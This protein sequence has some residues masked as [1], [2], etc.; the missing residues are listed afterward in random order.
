MLKVINKYCLKQATVEP[1]IAE[2]YS[3][4][5]ELISQ[6]DPFFDCMNG[7]EASS[8]TGPKLGSCKIK[9]MNDPVIGRLK[10]ALLFF[11]KWHDGAGSKT[12]FMTD[13]CW[14]DVQ[15]MVLGV[16]TVVELFCYETFVTKPSRR[17][18]TKTTSRIKE[19]RF[20]AGPRRKRKC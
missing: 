15:F 7:T 17:S 1:G 9:T 12:E 13:E 5:V 10:D 2:R 19:P 16:L 3:G 11:Q 18:S 8:R 14:A 20:R 4:L 6:V